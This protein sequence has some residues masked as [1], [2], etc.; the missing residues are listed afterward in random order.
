MLWQEKEEGINAG[1]LTNKDS[2]YWNGTLL[3]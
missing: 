2:Q 3:L 1:K